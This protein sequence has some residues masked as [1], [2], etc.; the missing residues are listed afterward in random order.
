MLQHSIMTEIDSQDVS[1]Q[2]TFHSLPKPASGAYHNRAASTGRP[3]YQGEQKSIRSL[4]HYPS[5]FIGQLRPA[6]MGRG[7]SPAL[8]ARHTDAEDGPSAAHAHIDFSES[9]TCRPR[10][11]HAQKKW[12]ASTPALV[13][14]LGW[15]GCES[16]TRSSICDMSTPTPRGAVCAGLA[17]RC[18]FFAR[19]K[20]SVRGGTI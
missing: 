17:C 3:A 16:F 20:E 12:P 11:T 8:T 18:L 7:G 19:R 5:R 9:P 10:S 6:Y 4:T 1:R 13:R 14:P 15:D 2:G